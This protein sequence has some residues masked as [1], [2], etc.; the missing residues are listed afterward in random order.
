M[1]LGF[2]ANKPDFGNISKTIEEIDFLD[3]LKKIVI[4]R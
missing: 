2:Y 1:I 3:Y 4:Y